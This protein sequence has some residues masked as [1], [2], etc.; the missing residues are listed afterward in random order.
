[1]T[2]YIPDGLKKISLKNEIMKILDIDDY[3]ILSRGRFFFK[4]DTKDRKTMKKKIL[5]CKLHKMEN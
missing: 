5:L 1:M 3:T 2:K 4:P